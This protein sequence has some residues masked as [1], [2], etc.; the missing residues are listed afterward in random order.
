MYYLLFT[1]QSVYGLE[2]G[3]CGQ[4]VAEVRNRTEWTLLRQK[5][6]SNPKC[7]PPSLFRAS[8][9][10]NE[11]HYKGVHSRLSLRPLLVSLLP[12]LQN[13]AVD[14]AATVV[15]GRV[16][17]QGDAVLRCAGALGLAR[18]ARGICSRRAHMKVPPSMNKDTPTWKQKST[19]WFG[20]FLEPNIPATAQDHLRVRQNYW[21]PI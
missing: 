18:G 9:I 20:Q 4:N 12:L 15:L 21:T 17:L 3:P 16:P 11:A 14:G 10:L 7:Q 6:S 13:V 2:T 8:Q 19:Q 1:W 5:L